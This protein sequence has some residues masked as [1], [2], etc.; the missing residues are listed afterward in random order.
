MELFLEKGQKKKKKSH[1]TLRDLPPLTSQ[2]ELEQSSVVPGPPAANASTGHV[3]TT[4]SAPV[5]NLQPEIRVD[6]MA[7]GL[8]TRRRATKVSNT[9]RGRANP[10]PRS[11][12]CRVRMRAQAGNQH[13]GYIKAL[14]VIYSN[15]TRAWWCGVIP[16]AHFLW[17]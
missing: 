9:P 3:H 2:Q 5:G 11:L 15:V 12:V 7:K 14:L 17:S 1:Q 4:G 16:W 8:G 10:H 6:I 13:K